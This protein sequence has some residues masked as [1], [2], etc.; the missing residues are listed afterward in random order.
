MKHGLKCW[1]IWSLA[2]GCACVFY[3]LTVARPLAEGWRLLTEAWQAPID[4]VRI[5]APNAPETA[6][7][8]VLQA[9]LDQQERINGGN[10]PVWV[11]MLAVDQHGSTVWDAARATMLARLNE[12]RAWLTRDFARPLII[13]LPENW[14]RG[15]VCLVVLQSGRSIA[16]S[17]V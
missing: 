11:E 15:G 16:D 8:A 14:V 1:C 17:V 13:C 5:V 12:S 7:R 4:L 3:F 9:L 10:A 6:S 2:S